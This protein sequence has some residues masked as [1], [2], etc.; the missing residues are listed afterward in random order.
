MWP[1]QGVFQGVLKLCYKGLT[2]RNLQHG[3]I[4]IKCYNS[5]NTNQ[6]G[7]KLTICTKDILKFTKVLLF[8]KKFFSGGRVSK[9]RQKTRKIGD[10]GN[11]FGYH[12]H[13]IA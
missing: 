6:F 9:N 1:Q 12:R 3:K 13:E 5:V 10:F 11:F 2:S 7:I 4:A 8:E